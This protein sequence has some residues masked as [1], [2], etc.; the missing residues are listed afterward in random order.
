MEID[1]NAMF[2]LLEGYG[3]EGIIQ[4]MNGYAA[5]VNTLNGLDITNESFTHLLL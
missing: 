5:G 3:T 1:I 4:Q 2:E